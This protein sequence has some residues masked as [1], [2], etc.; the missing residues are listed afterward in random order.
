MSAS[1]YRGELERKRKQRSDAEKKAGEA[2]SKE[3]QKRS[4]S[5]RA[6]LAASKATS[7]SSIQSKLREAERRDKEAEAAGKD[8]ARWQA[9][10]STYLRDETSITSKLLRA[11]QSELEA[12]ERRR[13][14]DEEQRERQA[15]AARQ[16]LVSRMDTAETSLQIALRTLPAPKP[17]RLRVLI[18]GASADGELRVGR[19]Q[20]RIRAAVESA[21]HREQIELD[22]RPA[23]TTQDLL[24]GITK[25]RPHVV[26]FSGHSGAD[27]IVFED[28]EDERHEG[29]AVSAHAFAM[30]V[31]ATDQ[32][33]LLV[34]LNSC[35]SASQIDELVAS[36]APF[37]IGMADSIEDADAI[38]YA[39]QFYA[40][41]ANGQSIRSAHLSGQAAL[42]LAGLETAALPTLASAPDAD[43]ST[44]VLVQQPHEVP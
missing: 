1:Q 39:A 26:H 22:V 33:P 11:E 24:D 9:K 6:R 7:S 41:V 30:A 19:E 40:A 43:P 10:A 34:L 29:T 36:V 4:D 16:D 38:N 17:E 42:E 32:P 8:A 31:R 35:N 21:L 15:I 18:L 25:F 37:A 20:K 28:E 3:S 5:A 14:R 27:L 13:K 23:A 44:A 12:S 2:R